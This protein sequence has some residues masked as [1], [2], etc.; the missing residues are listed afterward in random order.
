MISRAGGL[1][2]L[3]S[4]TDPKLCAILQRSCWRSASSANRTIE[5]I[6]IGDKMLM[7]IDMPPRRGELG[8]FIMDAFICRDDGRSQAVQIYPVPARTDGG[9]GSGCCLGAVLSGGLSPPLPGLRDLAEG[10]GWSWALGSPSAWPAGRWED[11][12]G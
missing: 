2:I 7:L 8:P 4:L 5:P 12:G 10:C 11:G 6:R 1:F 9:R 3:A